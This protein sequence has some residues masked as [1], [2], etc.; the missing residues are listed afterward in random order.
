MSRPEVSEEHVKV[1][2]RLDRNV[3]V[4]YLRLQT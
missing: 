1:V 4:S 2:Y 3:Y